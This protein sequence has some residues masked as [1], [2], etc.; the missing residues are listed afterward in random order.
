VFVTPQTRHVRHVLATLLT[1]GV[2]L[3]VWLAVCIERSMRPWRCKECGWHKPEFRVPLRE[4]LEMGESA[5]HGTRRQSA[6]R[7]LRRDLKESQRLA[8]KLD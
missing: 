4:A 3:F 5:L 8:V 6:I 7:M 2:W 1:G